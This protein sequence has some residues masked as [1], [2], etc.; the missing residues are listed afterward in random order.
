M[1]KN[2]EQC[3]NSEQKWLQKKILTNFLHHKKSL[4]ISQP[5]SSNFHV[6]FYI[7]FRLEKTIFHPILTFAGA[8]SF[9]GD[10]DRRVVDAIVVF[11]PAWGA[12]RAIIASAKE[13]RLNHGALLTSGTKKK[14][15]RAVLNC[16]T[17][18]NLIA[19]V[20]VSFPCYFLPFTIFITFH[21]VVAVSS[22]VIKIPRFFLSFRRIFFYFRG[23][24]LLPHD[25]H[26]SSSR[27]FLRE[28]KIRKKSFISIF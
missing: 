23:I 5:L 19:R 9:A 7:I 22:V 24:F 6:E 21:G 26:R 17:R 28:G 8:E 3:Y 15:A 11:Q 20:C 4:L 13:R 18:N 27:R 12:V 1:L 2:L 25:Y 16:S 14:R 10:A